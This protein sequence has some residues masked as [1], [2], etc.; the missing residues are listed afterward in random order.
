MPN[1]QDIFQLAQQTA[2][3][4]T[5]SPENWRRFLYTAAHNYHTTYLNQLLIHAQRPD[6]TACATMKYWNEQAHR[7]V[8]YGS[9]SII[10]LQRHQGVPTAK[11]VFSMTDTVLTGD[12]AAAPWEVTDAIRPLL[13]QVNSV[14]SLMDRATEQVVSLSD[15]ANRVL[16][17]SIEDS[18]L[19][20]SHPEDQRFILQ[21]VAAQSTLYMV[22]IR[23]GIPVR[24][25]DFPAFRNVTQFD[26][27]RISLC[28]GGYV[29]A[30]AE[31]LLDELGH[32][33]M[34]LARDS[35]AIQAEPVHN[36]DTQSPTQTTSREEAVTDDVHER[37]GLSDSEPELAE[38]QE[39]QPEPVRQ[40]AAGLL[41]AERAEPVR[42][43]DAGGNAAAEL[44][45]DGAGRTAAGGQDAARL[46][47]ESADARPQD[48]PAGLG[49]DVQQPEATGGGNDPS[50]AVRSITEE[51]AAAESEESPS[52]FS[53]PEFPAELLPSLLKADTTSRASNADILSFFSKTPLLID[54]LRYIRESYK[55]VF[56][57]LL[58][59][60]DTRVGFYKESNG[61]LVWRGS[62]LTRS[63]ESHLSWHSVT[64]AISALVDNHELIAAI[65]PK[66]AVSQDE[67]LSF[68]LPEN[69]SRGDEVG[70]LEVDDIYSEEEQDEK[71]KAALPTYHYKEP[72]PDDGSHITE[73]D[74][75]VIITRGS[76]FEGGKYR[77]YNH[78]QQ[79]KTEKETV[80]FLKKEYG[81]GGFCWTFADGGSGFVNFDGKGFSILYDFKNDL[82]Y[83]K[84]LKWKEVGKRLEYLVR[85]DRYLT[86]AEREKMPAWIN[87]QTESKPLLPPIP[88]QKPV[89]KVGSTVYLENDQRFTVESIGQF[90]VHLRNE[91]F[92]LVG[93]AV[94]R[95]QF[96]QLLDA[97]HRNGGMVLS[98]QQRE[99]LVQEQREQALSYIED[100]LK[101]EFEITEPDFSDLTQI[102]LGYTTTE[103]EQH[104]IQVHADL[105]HCTISKF[106][107]DTLYAQDT[108]ASLEDMNRMALA[109]L[110][111][112]SLMEVDI[113]EIEEQEPEISADEPVESTFVSQVMEDVDRLA[114]REE[115]AE[116][117]RT[118][119]LAPYEPAIPEGPKA[120]FAANVQA[121]RTLKE[122]EQRMASGGAPASEEEQDILAGYLG[123][124][125]L[126]DAFD[127][128][129]DNWHT[130]YEQLKTLLTEDEYA[131]ARES[132]LTAFYTP[133]A[134]IHAMYRA[135]EHIGCVGGNVLEPSM[136]VGA[137]FG[138]RH[139]KFDTH[140]A[141]LY[142][143]ELD[144]LSGRIAQQLYQKAKI[145]ITG[146]EKAD[147]P[148]NFFDLAIGNV[149]FGQ[150]QVSDRRYDKLHFQIHDYFLAK[151]V[152]K[153]RV[154]GI[155]AFITTS[156]TLD[157]KSEEVRKYLAARCDLIGAVR[158]PNT[159]FKSNAGTE[160]TSDILFLQKRGRV[161]EQDA[162][163]IHVGETENGIPLNQ[164]FIDHPEMVCGEMQ[165]VS[166]PYGMRSTCVPNEQ[167]PLAEQLD[168]ALSTLHAEYTLV[169]EQEYAEEE[170]G[171][172]DA[173]P[174]VRN[175]SYTVKDDVIYY[176]ENSKMRVVKGGETA[177][178]RIRALVPLRDT[179]RELIDA[180][181]ENFPDE[182]IE[183]LQAR[184]NDQYD[185]YRKK[186]GLINSRG[187]ASAFREDSGYFLLCSLED[188]DD[189]GN[190]KGKTDMFTKRTI[191][192]AQAV[193]H[194]DTAEE[195]LALS[196]SEQGHVD[197]GYMSK[198]TGRTT[199]AIINDLTGIIFR[200]PVKVD[201]D[202]NPIYLPADEYLSGNV[203]E[204]LQ[205]AK[206]VAANDPQ[207]QINV[208]AL[209]KVQPKDLE[210]SEISVRLGATWIPAE[211][212]QQFLEELLD[213]PYYTRRVVKVEFAAY[214][215]SW[216][217]TNKK[218]G[219]GNIKATVTYGTN[220]ANAYL[221]AENALNLRSTQIRDKV[222]AA[223]GSVSWVLNKEATQAAQ[224]KQRQICEQFQDWIFKEPERRQRLVA[225]YNEKFNAL[226][227]REY[228]G[229]HLKFP[230]MNPEITL[231]PHQLN[232]IAHVLYGNNVLLAHEVGA[233]KTYE[234]VASAMEKKR[235][236]LCNKTLIVVPNHLTEQMASEALLLYPN[237]EIL[238]AKKT[239]FKKENRKKFC[240]RIAT[241]NYDIIVIGHSQ[242]EKI[243]LSA[244]RQQMYLQKQI[245]DV[246]DQIALLKSSRAENF[247]I[248]QMERTRKQLKK[249][250]DKL[251]DQQR[252][253]DVVTFEDLGVD[254]LMVDEAHYF[255]NAMIAT[256]MRNVAGISQTESQKSSDMLMKCM[257]LDEV[258]GGHGIVFATGTPISNSMTEMYV[259]MRYLQRGLLEK[260][261]LLNFDSWASTFG[262]SITAIELNP[263]GTG[264]RTKTRFA[265]FYNLP[266]LMSLF[267][268]SADIQTAD[269]LHLPVPELVG[270]KPS[271]VVLQPSEVQKR[272]VK[273]LADRAEKV[274]SGK[275][276]PTEDN[277]LRITNDGRKLALDQRLM[278]PLLPDDP[279]SKA[280][281]CVDKVYEI[282]E[283]TKEQRSTQMIFCDL[284][285]PKED[286]F[287]V[288]NDVRNKLLAKGIPKEEV[289]F[290]H[291]ADT[292]TK[293]A[294]LFG[295][296]RNGT[297][298]VLMGSTQKMGAGT[299]VQ[300][301]L[302]ALHHLDCPWRP[303]DIAQRN[304]RMV[305]QGNLNK[306][307][308]IF[309]YVT[310][311]TFDSYSWQL[312][313]N[314]QK[315]ISQIMTSKSPARSCEDL[316]EAALTYAEVKALAAG[317]PMIKE[318]MDLDIQVARLRTLKAAYTSQHYRLED[319]I[320]VA[321]PRQIKGTEHR[322]RAFEQDI[323]TAKE[324]QSYDA[325]K[326]L[327][328]SIEL[329]GK[330]YDKREDAGKALLGL[331]GAAVRATKPVP[332]GHYAGFE[333]TVE[334][335]PLEKVFHAH[336]VGEATHTTELGNDAAGN[337]IRFQ[338]VVSALP[339]DLNRLH[340][341]LEQLTKQL[342]NAEE[343]LKQPFLQ[344]QE[345][346]DKSARLAELDALLNVGNDAPIIEGEAEELEEEPEDALIQSDD[347]LER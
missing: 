334:Y 216:A 276:Q 27:S 60:D 284:S 81:I 176:R 198:L 49:A 182:Y 98:E 159:T 131:A 1:P 266:E 141:K 20:W 178:A 317:N 148:D 245:D 18:A 213:A 91:D 215:G 209:E 241:G 274:R 157:K 133:P 86:D 69:A 328:F 26:T 336:L 10:I 87:R 128:G 42:P 179:C 337:M 311:S 302:I 181:L 19:N 254:S 338:N 29:Q 82:R 298:R 144:S 51:P 265:R 140:N 165:M 196:L 64:A 94:S 344:E 56:T 232:A 234:M 45:Q 145:Q 154:G 24:E 132:T 185:A 312:V 259:M 252:K 214:T 152:D 262:E 14:G 101:D 102:G 281:A 143:V 195:S 210:A 8:M 120:K 285:T 43:D 174:N 309:I 150:Y 172:I 104:T 263:T 191:R 129:K 189:E 307:V 282:W 248:K 211:Y 223:D 272:M 345:L 46:D 186:Y 39:N 236:G 161:L 289:Q 175:F 244:E 168:A 310:E 40:D 323:Q 243:P 325:D 314:K 342:T 137:F 207:F 48:K 153:L 341:S 343:E 119:Y 111:F 273:G 221:I 219:D 76:V 339:Q 192:P 41:G 319:A 134:V 304:G 146:Y 239:D 267:K 113:N 226:R 12:K 330:I 123:W 275:V 163:W 52:A 13:M 83:E 117:D 15:R 225:I 231:R 93:R 35:V 122:I 173:D 229:S 255:K 78:F 37:E 127:P 118:N 100:Y 96:Q 21:E 200:D 177:L 63:A 169:D 228:D 301:R 279:G 11:R 58:L 30:A 256:K 99:S 92:P 258:T 115:P 246:I 171:T 6:A 240:A 264:Y 5:A 217:I 109:N 288:Y 331:V 68:D 294:E 34:Q 203:R 105:E 202:G 346:S 136:G 199:E 89:C 197:L 28:L 237:A 103:D 227:P 303:A 114:A 32:E 17:T 77:I 151:T 270:G 155:M 95:E 121:I 233:G 33:V 230:G 55:V 116:Y 110:D 158:L 201:T 106:V 90:D 61:L 250:L 299:N 183:K 204:K 142:G 84:K 335:K 224:E 295:K 139:S 283:K 271:N 286:G 74:V 242:F 50:D 38:D 2:T 222:T 156:G 124:G 290:I 80:A 326:K 340:G 72:Q 305:R 23:L 308:S 7:K 306:E 269:M 36:T 190:F 67:Q 220:R 327:I 278:N 97:N 75:N 130:E 235:L 206:A 126:A 70:A 208:A 25:E 149:P 205:A 277:M 313:E 333:I 135:L 125:G 296:V 16:A 44:P 287:D 3:Q 332:V 162:P 247:T 85:M 66:K 218:F 59:E 71:I 166:G 170:S 79:K 188:L 187:T 164:Y 300:T 251:N 47:A 212:V 280:N 321:F 54:R 320:A 9:K 322:I 31:P 65:D 318:K 73:D 88:D 160:V 53:L 4:V 108:Y 347:E 194:V 249:K 138:H 107:D 253:D 293:K 238:V 184:L 112:D 193:D 316:D 292:E 297:V 257:Y 261:G 147:L 329:D 268:M 22:C 260:E 324:H 167:S 180:Q 315:F 57:E 291:D 62:Y